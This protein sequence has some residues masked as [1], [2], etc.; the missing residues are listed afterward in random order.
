MEKNVKEP[1]FHI[2][3][4]ANIS[5]KKAILIRAIAIVSAMILCGLIFFL[6]VGKNPVDF[7][8]ALVQGAFGT[9]R[10]ICASFSC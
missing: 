8:V 5:T 10:R 6:L 1:L 7:Y 4:R 9:K 3:K 2:I